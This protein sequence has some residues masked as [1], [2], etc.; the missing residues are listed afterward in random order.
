M[1]CENKVMSSARTTA[2]SCPCRTN[3]PTT[4]DETL[5][6]ADVFKQGVKKRIFIQAT[7][8]LSQA[9]KFPCLAT[10]F[11]PPDPLFRV[12]P[13]LQG[14]AQ[15]LQPAS[16]QRVRRPSLSLGDAQA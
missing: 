1:G 11:W 3:S 12:L 9:R 15:A 14:Y 4:R 7:F 16:R 8:Q 13:Y 10:V 5:P 6:I 2:T